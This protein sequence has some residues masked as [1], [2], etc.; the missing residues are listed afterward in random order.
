MTGPKHV[1]HGDD[2]ASI[3]ARFLT[4]EADGVLGRME[5]AAATLLG[6]RAEPASASAR[7]MADGCRRLA[8]VFR[9]LALLLEDQASGTPS[10]ATD[11]EPASILSFPP[12]RLDLVNEA[13]WR[14]GAELALR[15]KPFQI[16]R[17]FAE[18]PQ[19]LVTQSELIEAV[20]GKVVRCDS[21]LRTHVR[22]L[23]RVLGGGVI[24]TVNGRGYR[25]VPVVSRLAGPIPFGRPRRRRASD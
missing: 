1:A 5:A 20:W 25:F 7:N 3:V 19:R 17:Y 16:L 13:L 18:H 9:V 14:D 23:R 22:V 24:E 21:L 12:F 10:V 2:P 11:T 15:N 4:R 6:S 8:T